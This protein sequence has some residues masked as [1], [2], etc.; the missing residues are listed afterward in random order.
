MPDYSAGSLLGFGVS[1]ER[2]ASQVKSRSCR[3][4]VKLL[5]KSRLQWRDIRLFIGNCQE[6]LKDLLRCSFETILNALCPNR[7]P[8]CVLV[9]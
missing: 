9:V 8:S 3:F 6:N 7:L 4:A 1:R 5:N 2:S